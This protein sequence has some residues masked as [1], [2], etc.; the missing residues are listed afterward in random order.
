MF[1]LSY[2]RLDFSC[3]YLDLLLDFEF[4]YNIDI[5][6]DYKNP[7]SRSGLATCFYMYQPLAKSGNWK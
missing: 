1:Y 4:N 6:Q 2:L 7:S 3:R 5:E